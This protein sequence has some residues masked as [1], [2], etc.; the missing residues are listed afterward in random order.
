VLRLAE[1]D[2]LR[3]ELNFRSKLLVACIDDYRLFWAGQEAEEAWFD[4][5]SRNS[6]QRTVRSCEMWSVAVR[7]VEGQAL[8][9]VSI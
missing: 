2:R 3:L 8:T 7:I 9:V 5:K 6:L 1:F 4:G